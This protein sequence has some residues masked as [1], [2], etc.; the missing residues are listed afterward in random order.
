MNPEYAVLRRAAASLRRAA[1][2]AEAID[3]D[4]VAWKLMALAVEHSSAELDALD[5]EG[6]TYALKLDEPLTFG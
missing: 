2:A 6:Q 3:G 1:K 4:V 5:E